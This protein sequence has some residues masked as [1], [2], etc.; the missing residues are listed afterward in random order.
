MA[1]NHQNTE[2]MASLTPNQPQNTK[3]RITFNMF[4]SLA[5]EIALQAFVGL[6]YFFLQSLMPSKAS[7]I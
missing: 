5:F 7:G 6:L 4:A 3:K 1:L 2:I